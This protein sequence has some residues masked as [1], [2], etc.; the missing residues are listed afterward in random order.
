MLTPPTVFIWSIPVMDVE[1][2]MFMED[3]VAL[4]NAVYPI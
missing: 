2:T 1:R 4:E 3:S